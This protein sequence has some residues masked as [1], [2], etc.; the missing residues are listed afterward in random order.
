MFSITYIVMLLVPNGFAWFL[1]IYG[2]LFMCRCTRSY[3]RVNSYLHICI[4]TRGQS[5]VLFQRSCPPYLLKQGLCD[6]DPTEQARP[7]GQQIPEI[8]SLPPQ[9]RDDKCAWLLHGCWEPDLC[10]HTFTTELSH[11][12]HL[13]SPVE[14]CHCDHQTTVL[15]KIFSW[16]HHKD[17]P[18]QTVSLN[19]SIPEMISFFLE[20][21][22]GEVMSLAFDTHLEHAFI[23]LP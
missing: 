5:W 12:S 2:C 17:H 6:L 18:F 4:E 3:M 21:R 8:S 23:K 16:K 7:T 20:K 15:Q 22:L 13:P 14:I 1:F 11:L 19:Y 10:P 9:N